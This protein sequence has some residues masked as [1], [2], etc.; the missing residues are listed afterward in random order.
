[1]QEI[2]LEISSSKKRTG[3]FVIDDL[4]IGIFIIIIFYEQLMELT[5]PES[6]AQFNSNTFLSIILLKIIYQ[7]FLVWQNSG[8]TIGKYIMKIKVIE[9]ENG[10]SPSFQVSLHRAILRVLSEFIFYVGFSSFYKS[11]ISD[12]A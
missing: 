9:L 1:M 4:V 5:T 6:I 8:K 11:Y 12:D 7:T 10:N 2:K 3:A